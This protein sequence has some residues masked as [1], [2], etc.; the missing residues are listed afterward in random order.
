MKFTKG[1]GENGKSEALE[2]ELVSERPDTIKDDSDHKTVILYA[3]HSVEISN[4][5][6][7]GLIHFLSY[8]SM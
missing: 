6:L 8:L 4:E 5:I 3:N 1:E 7:D 2:V